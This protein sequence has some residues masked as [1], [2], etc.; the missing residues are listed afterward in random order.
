MI[1]A[2]ESFVKAYDAQDQA[3]LSIAIEDLQN[4]AKKYYDYKCGKF[5]PTPL[6]QLILQ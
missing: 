1:A 4:A 2:L 3:A 6:Q 5:N